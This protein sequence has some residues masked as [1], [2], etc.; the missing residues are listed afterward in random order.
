MLVGPKASWYLKL[1]S[2]AGAGAGAGAVGAGEAG[3]AQPAGS[4]TTVITMIRNINNPADNIRL[5][6]NFTSN[7][8]Y[9]S[10]NFV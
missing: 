3:E 9:G 7:L 6:F 1:N 8:L 10:Y 5:C 4:V 2:A